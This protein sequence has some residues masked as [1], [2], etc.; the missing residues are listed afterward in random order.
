MK[1]ELT[2][3]ERIVAEVERRWRARTPAIR[4]DE[5][6]PATR[7][8]RGEMRLWAKQNSV[9]YDDLD[10]DLALALDKMFRRLRK[11]FPKERWERG[12]PKW[13]RVM[14]A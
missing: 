13:R 10:P 12:I 9:K 7:V 11:E 5:V 6:D 3:V 8:S 4:I 14:E 1:S 2:D